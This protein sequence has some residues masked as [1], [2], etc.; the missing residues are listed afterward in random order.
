MSPVFFA[1][2]GLQRARDLAPY[3]DFGGVMQ[4][5][6]I[7]ETAPPS[8]GQMFGDLLRDG[9]DV[10][11][12]LL[13]WCDSQNNINRRMSAQ[14][15]REFEMRIVFQMSLQDSLALIDSPMAAKLGPYRALFVSDDEG[16]LDKFKP[17][18]LPKVEWIQ[19]LKRTEK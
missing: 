13:V 9:P 8:P 6:G 11:I 16:R 14:T 15:V 4:F 10:G 5:G 19:S 12:H 18:A 17:F 2:Y 3:D 1:I 7:D